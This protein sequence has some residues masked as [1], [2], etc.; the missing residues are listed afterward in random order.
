MADATVVANTSKRSTGADGGGA[1][2]AG[3]GVAKD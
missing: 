3:G 1:D 2:P